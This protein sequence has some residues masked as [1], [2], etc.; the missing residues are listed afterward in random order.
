MQGFTKTMLA[1]LTATLAITGCGKN[2]QPDTD[3]PK[4]HVEK[5]NIGQTEVTI[6]VEPDKV[7]LDR[8]VM[9]TLRAVSPQSTSVNFPPIT[10]RITGFLDAGHFDREPVEAD[11]KRTIERVIRLTPTIAKE[12]RIAPMAITCLDNKTNPPQ[13]SWGPTP[14]ITL[15]LQPL[16]NKA[17][18]SNI[19][20]VLTPSW[21][22]PAMSTIAF[23]IAIACIAICAV[24]ILFKL[25]KRIRRQVQLMRMSPRERALEEL[26]ELL[27]K[28]LIEKHLIKD[29]YVE[30]TMI[31]R[32]YIERQHKI[33][34]P[35]QTTEEFLQAVKDN[36]RFSPEIINRLRDF[37]QAADLV[38]FAAH[39]PDQSNI[40]NAVN[41]A[42]EYVTSDAARA[43]QEQ[44]QNNSKEG[45][46]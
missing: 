26:R 5:I 23:Y 6:S 14:P 2:D 7:F 28:Q 11:G 24:F 33:R 40:D 32:R 12:Y 45:E 27:G 19:S 18:G 38:K 1:L 37:L 36:S 13:K 4:A 42:K 30:L 35:E 44:A 46:L 41:S 20:G 25:A 21:I 43:E 9:L 16:S 3:A 34:A 31:V 8:D 15:P 17:P 10:D 39:Q 29:F 22:H